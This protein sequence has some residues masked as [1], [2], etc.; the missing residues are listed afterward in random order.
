MFRRMFWFVLGAVAG[1]YGVTAARK[2]AADLGEKLTLANALELL[3]AS[4]K[5]LVESIV[6]AWNRRQGGDTDM[7]SAP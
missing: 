3:V 7:T 4:A 2:K 5:Q 6:A 1:V